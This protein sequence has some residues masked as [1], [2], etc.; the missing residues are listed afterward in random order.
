MYFMQLDLE[1]CFIY[2]NVLPFFYKSAISGR[3]RGNIDASKR[4][5]STALLH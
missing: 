5:K 2:V 3:R 1:V 4:N